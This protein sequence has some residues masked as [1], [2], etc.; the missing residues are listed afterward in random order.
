[1]A[2]F[3]WQRFKVIIIKFADRLNNMQTIEYLSLKKKRITTR[4]KILFP[5]LIAWYGKLKMGFRRFIFK[6]FRPKHKSID[7]KI[8]ESSKKDSVV[9]DNNIKPVKKLKNKIKSDIF[10]RYKSISSILEKYNYRIKI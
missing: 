6:M 4:Q 7:K 3:H 2:H 1:M 8:S 10:C 5:W 9:I